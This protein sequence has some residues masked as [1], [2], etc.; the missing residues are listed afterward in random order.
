ME[1]TAREKF[2]YYTLGITPPAISREWVERDINSAGWQVRR[3]LQVWIGMAF[4]LAVVGP[5]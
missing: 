5:L 4:G 3:F 2:L 1:P